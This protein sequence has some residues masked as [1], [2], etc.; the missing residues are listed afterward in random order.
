MYQC[1]TILLKSN[2]LKTSKCYLITIK[3]NDNLKLKIV[4]DKILI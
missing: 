4:I 3:K 2:Y 1:F